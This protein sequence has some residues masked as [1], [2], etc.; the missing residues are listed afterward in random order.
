MAGM[1]AHPDG[2][3]PGPRAFRPRTPVVIGLVGGIAAGK[4]T[5]AGQ[6][7]ARG[8]CL[9]DADRLA[10]EA[11]EDPEVV[12]EV[13]A[14]LGER[15]TAGGRLDR[16]ALAEH[17]FGDP[18]RR[19][20]LEAILHPRIRARIV[21]ALDQAR[22]AGDSALVDAPLMFETGLSEH[23]DVVVFVAAPDVVR[24]ARAAGRG[25]APDE[26]ARREQ[27]QLPLAEKRARAD[28]VIDNGG[29]L[30]ATDRA[31]DEL[32]RSLAKTPA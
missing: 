23:C 20:E 2:T 14:R 3:G 16:A 18:D 7:A 13:T 27:S 12:R 31:V 9:I 4:S 25:W 6:F 11:A 5:V 10:R 32:L 1:P 28:H 26:L 22:S 21:H 15:F 24:Q 17:V 19:R 30:A 8:L 29:D